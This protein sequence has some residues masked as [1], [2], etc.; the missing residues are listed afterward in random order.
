MFQSAKFQELL[1]AYDLLDNSKEKPNK[2]INDDSDDESDHDDSKTAFEDDE[3]YEN[4]HNFDSI[5]QL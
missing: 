5:Q 3:E 4:T 2:L 1:N